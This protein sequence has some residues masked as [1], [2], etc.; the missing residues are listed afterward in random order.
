MYE[1]T[2][3]LNST[4]IHELL[5]AVEL[6]MKL[7]LGQYQE[8]VYDLC[9]IHSPSEAENISNADDLLREAFELIYKEKKVSE[10]N[11]PAE[12]SEPPAEETVK[13]PDDTQML[14]E[15]LKNPE[16]V[17]LLRSLINQK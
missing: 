16:V 3:K 5:K 2:L 1:Y 4:N 7:K 6:L 12:A 13:E 14:L 17:G 10:Y 8:I 11:E 15:L 9:D